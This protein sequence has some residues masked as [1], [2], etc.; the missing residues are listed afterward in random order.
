[1]L[2]AQVVQ[3]GDARI[4]PNQAGHLFGLLLFARERLIDFLEMFWIYSSVVQRRGRRNQ[5]RGQHF[6]VVNHRNRWNDMNF[7]IHRINSRARFRRH[8]ASQLTQSYHAAFR[9]K[10]QIT[11][12]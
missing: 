5:T 6:L 4:Q 2:R 7:A 8:F 11:S 12:S 10:T 9:S 3:Q 1:M